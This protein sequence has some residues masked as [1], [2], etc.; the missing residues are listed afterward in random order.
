MADFNN[1]KRELLKGLDEGVVAPAPVKPSTKPETEPRPETPERDPKPIWPSREPAPGVQPGPKQKE[2]GAAP[3][4]APAPVKPAVEPETIPE[5]PEKERPLWPTRE[6][7][8]HPGVRPGPKQSSCLSCIGVDIKGMEEAYEDEVHPDVQRFWSDFPNAKN[9]GQKHI[10]HQHPIM[11]LY[12]DKLSRA[13]YEDVSERGEQAGVQ[14]SP[15]QL[16]G[17]IMEIS[18]L[19]RGH[20]KELVDIAK[21]VTHEILGIPMNMLDGE[22]VPIGGMPAETLEKIRH[23]KEGDR[24]AY[25]DLP[26]STKKKIQKRVTINA[27]THGGSMHSMYT[28]HHLARD[29]LLKLGEQKD[30]VKKLLELYNMLAP[31]VHKPYWLTG[32]EEVMLAAQSPQANAGLAW[33][34]QESGKA[35]AVGIAFPILIHEM[36][37]AGM[38]KLSHFGLENVDE[39]EGKQVLRYADRAVDEMWLLQ[40]GKDLWKRFLA[41]INKIEDRPSN[42]MILAALYR[43]DP[44]E[45][46][47]IIMAILDDSERAEELLEK[48][49][50][51]GDV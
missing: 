38:E 17:L 44:D 25:E 33:V 32:V 2:R 41:A 36:I 37:K 20:E 49:V 14:Y 18:R 5:P 29:Y 7:N 8:K 1:W 34:D 46:H 10:F 40:V 28:A 4:V 51:T 43:K 16:M 19:E 26:E 39:E 50:R 23:E 31:V 6:P 24:E 27:M 21:K 11:R 47:D 15:A 35:K 45:V 9:P 42:A 22:I 13:S 48:L 12:G 30:W 3:G